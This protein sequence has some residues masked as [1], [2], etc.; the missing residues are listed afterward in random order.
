MKLIKSLLILFILALSN[1]STRALH[2]ISSLTHS[3]SYSHDGEG[4]WKTKYVCPKIRTFRGVLKDIDLNVTFEAKQIESPANDE[5]KFGLILYFSEPPKDYML[6]ILEHLDSRGGKKYYLPY[7]N[8][9]SDFQLK[10]TGG[11]FSGDHPS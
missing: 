1:I 5:E 10:I 11:I 2:K 6:R 3:K 9:Y 4:T 7:K 8:I